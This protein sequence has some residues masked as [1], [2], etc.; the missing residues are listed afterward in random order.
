MHLIAWPPRQ[1]GAYVRMLV[2]RIVV[3]DQ[4][5]IEV[6]RDVLIDALEEGEKQRSHTSPVLEDMTRP[7]APPRSYR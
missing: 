5:D 7:F 2:C 6:G 1:P 3:A 4:V